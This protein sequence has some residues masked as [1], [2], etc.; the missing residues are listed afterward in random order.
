MKHILVASD[1][2]VRSDRATRRA[3]A[4]I[5]ETEAK[6][7]ILHIV[8]SAM[9]MHLAEAVVT[10]ARETL[11]DVVAS[12][13][14][15]RTDQIDIRITIGD[16]VAEIATRAEKVAADLLVVGLHR[17][18]QFLDLLKETTMERLIKVSKTPVL[19]VMNPAAHE[20]NDLLCAINMSPACA[21]AVN[22]SRTIAPSGKQRLFHAFH[23]PYRGLVNPGEPAE[24]VVI[25]RNEAQEA[26]AA[27]RDNSVLPDDLPEPTFVDG[28]PSTALVQMMN[29]GKPDMLV[30]GAHGR[31]NIG[32]YMLGGFTAGLIRYPPCDLLVAR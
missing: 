14:S 20:Y 2:S 15:K 6:L 11:E 19:L 8:D 7:T 22:V 3:I 17:E 23:V 4:L 27:W 9:P 10:T 24:G 28:G 12:A 16:P 1:L 18:R 5:D 13:K 32:R 26:F 30:M 31:S 29:A 21:K 25:Y